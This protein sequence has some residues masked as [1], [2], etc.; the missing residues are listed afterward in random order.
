MPSQDTT[1]I[2][3]EVHEGNWDAYSINSEPTERDRM[4]LR[5]IQA[6]GVNE[7]VT[8]GLWAFTITE[9]EGVQMLHLL[10]LDTSK[11][12]SRLRASRGH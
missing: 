6:V 1:P 4:L 2:V 5:T 12:G 9:V 10:P 8:D 11:V 7:S 3:V